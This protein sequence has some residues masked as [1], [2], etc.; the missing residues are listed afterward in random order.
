M[1]FAM[2]SMMRRALSA[3]SASGVEMNTRPSSSMSIFTPVS[4]IIL[5][6]ILPPGPITS[7]I[8]SGLMVKRT[9]LGAYLL[10]SLRGSPMQLSIFSR[11]NRRPLSACASAVSR[12]VRSMPAIL[13]SIW[14]AV[15][16]FMEPATLKSMSPRKSSRP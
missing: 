8:F 4:A 5:L 1:S 15:M 9:I 2:P 16:P 14:M 3:A 7:R 13:M 11:M 6:I 12:I 10:S